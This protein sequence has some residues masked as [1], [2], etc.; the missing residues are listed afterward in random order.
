[1]KHPDFCKDCWKL[2]DCEQKHFMNATTES[3]SGY[4][5]FNACDHVCEN[6]IESEENAAPLDPS[7][8]IDYPA[9]CADCG[10]P[11]D[12]SLTDEGVRNVK[13]AIEDGEGCCRELWPVL[14]SDYLMEEV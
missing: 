7:T 13:E 9:H 8:A 4:V 11:L 14:W 3:V 5:D 1:M 2:S 10:V 12:H 6:C